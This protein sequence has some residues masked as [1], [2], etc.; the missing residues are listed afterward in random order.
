MPSSKTPKDSPKYFASHRVI[1]TLFFSQPTLTLQLVE[2]KPGNWINIINQTVTESLHFAERIDLGMEVVYE[3]PKT[4]IIDHVAYISF[5]EPH[6][7]PEAIFMAMGMK[8]QGQ[9]QHIFLMAVEKGKDDMNFLTAWR[10]DGKHLSFGPAPPALDLDVFKSC[11]REV[12]QGL[13]DDKK[14]DAETKAARY[15]VP[16]F[17]KTGEKDEQ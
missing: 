6:T 1:P 11:V 7:V 4:E 2:D 14:K 3:S 12:L 9:S 5:T 13:H 16:D 10:R 15:T 8:Q 17:K